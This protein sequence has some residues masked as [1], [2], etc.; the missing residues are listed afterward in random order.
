[1]TE[2]NLWK[3]KLAQDKNLTSTK[4][5][6]KWAMVNAAGEQMFILVNGLVVAQADDHGAGAAFR[7]TELMN[8]ADR[9]NAALSYAA[10]PRELAENLAKA[11]EIIKHDYE[12]GDNF[13][14]PRWQK[15]QEAI[16]AWEAFAGKEGV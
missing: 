8:M 2:P 9:I 1:M 11:M 16:A 15:C 4:K 7:I 13:H 12:D 10:V 5:T 3:S 6:V 14:E